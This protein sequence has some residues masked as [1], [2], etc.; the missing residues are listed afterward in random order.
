MLRKIKLADLIYSLGGV[1]VADMGVKVYNL[2]TLNDPAPQFFEYV[3][4]TVSTALNRKY[5]QWSYVYGPRVRRQKESA[6]EYERGKWDAA[7]EQ[8]FFD[9]W[10]WY[11]Q[12]NQHNWN[13]L[14]TAYL[15]EYNPLH[16][17]DRTEEHTSNEGW[18]ET[19]SD[20]TAAS[21]TGS[22]N[23]TST[24]ANNVTGSATKTDTTSEE[25]SAAQFAARS[26]TG[27]EASSQ[28]VNETGSEQRNEITSGTKDETNNIGNAVKIQKHIDGNFNYTPEAGAV[29]DGTLLPTQTNYATTYDNT[30]TDRKTGKQTAEGVSGDLIIDNAVSNKVTDDGSSEGTTDTARDTE[31]KGTSLR[32]LEGSE[33]SSGS[34][35]AVT[36]ATGAESHTEAAERSVSVTG[37]NDTNTV[38]NGSYDKTGNRA[39]SENLRAYGNIGVTTSVDMLKQE[40]EFRNFDL[41]E[42]IVDNFARKYLVLTP[43]AEEECDDEW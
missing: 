37:G 26:E 28:T 30:V 32:G 22:N 3:S 19:G 14:M 21:T 35:N 40:F 33:S 9:D 11:V 15:K 10:F 17:Y 5:G 34:S 18:G 25:T 39:G 16:N 41:L 12:D 4:S 42:Y 23:E 36:Q 7:A 6:E 38:T 2:D 20:N 31:T 8:A 43:Y 29:I 24:E 1:D 13:W 27:T